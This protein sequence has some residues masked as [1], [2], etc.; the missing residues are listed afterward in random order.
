[1]YYSA[2][3]PQFTYFERVV[4]SNLFVVFYGA[5][6]IPIHF[7]Q[8]DFLLCNKLDPHNQQ[9]CGSFCS[10]L[11][12]S[13]AWIIVFVKNIVDIQKFSRHCVTSIITKTK[14]M[15]VSTKTAMAKQLEAVAAAIF[16]LI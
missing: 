6:F 8:Q 11:C 9:Y 16:Q 13:L 4:S 15:F 2:A 7:S 10:A 14:L 5:Y 12:A 1:M 3:P